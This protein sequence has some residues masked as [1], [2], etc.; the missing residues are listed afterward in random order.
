MKREEKKRERDREKGRRGKTV[1]A[2]DHRAA[3]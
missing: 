2:R 3:I 1:V